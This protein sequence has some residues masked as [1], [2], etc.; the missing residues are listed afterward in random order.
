MNLR[1]QLIGFEGWVN[2]AYPDPLTHGDPWTIGVGHTGPDVRQGVVWDNDK[3]SRVLD[4]DI[5]EATAE[6]RKAFPWFDRLSNEPRRAVI[7]GMCFQMGIGRLS[8]FH[9]TLAAMRDEKWDHAANCMRDSLWA[10]Q[11]PKR[12]ARLAR[13]TE[14]GEWN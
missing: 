5:A 9:E 8:K 4:E 7:I 3:V 10:R 1:E 2:R 13:Q 6:V 12:A 14:T 11:T